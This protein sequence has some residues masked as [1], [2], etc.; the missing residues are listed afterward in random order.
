[1]YGSVT[2]GWIDVESHNLYKELAESLNIPADIGGVL[3]SDILDSG[4]ADKVV[5]KSGAVLTHANG[6][7]ESD[8]VTFLNRILQ[9]NP[10]A[11]MGL[12]GSR[13]AK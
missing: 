5:I 6:Q 3:I 11:E 12:N 2:R 4:P 1:V 9:T 10:G 13:P 7:K 8:L